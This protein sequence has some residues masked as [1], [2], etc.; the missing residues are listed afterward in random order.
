VNLVLAP[1]H[2]A[3]SSFQ[4]FIH[5]PSKSGRIARI[6]NIKLDV[7][8]KFITRSFQTLLVTGT[9]QA[10]TM[11]VP[12]MEYVTRKKYL[13]RMCCAGKGHFRNVNS[14]RAA[15][16]MLFPDKYP[17]VNAPDLKAL[18]SSYCLF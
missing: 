15:K 7:I 6:V 12:T 8:K 14:T 1:F 9:D 17:A 18:C 10:D 4:L 5:L 2:F 3:V 11:N 13:Y 16:Y